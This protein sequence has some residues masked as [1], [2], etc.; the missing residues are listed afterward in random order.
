MWLPSELAIGLAACVCAVGKSVSD[1][2]NWKTN[3]SRKI[4]AQ[5]AVTKVEKSQRFLNR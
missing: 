3:V 1:I 5:K 4:K 2:D